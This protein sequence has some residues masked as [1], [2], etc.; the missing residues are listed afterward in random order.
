M[1]TAIRQCRA[2][3]YYPSAISQSTLVC[4]QCGVQS[5][6]ICNNN[7]WNCGWCNKR[8]VSKRNLTTFQLPN[9]HLVG[10]LAGLHFKPAPGHNCPLL[11]MLN[12]SCCGR[13]IVSAHWQQHFSW[14]IAIVDTR[15][16]NL[17]CVLRKVEALT[18]LRNY[19]ALG[20][21]RYQVGRAGP[22]HH[23]SHEVRI[24]SCVS[25]INKGK[26]KI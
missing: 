2:Y 17:I 22:H 13:K 24:S 26:V 3:Y 15:E 10:V 19:E 12:A 6:Q 4:Q 14:I 11:K 5:E 23:I 9:L 25:T 16:P 18:M 7:I 21:I 1:C 20:Q 8:P